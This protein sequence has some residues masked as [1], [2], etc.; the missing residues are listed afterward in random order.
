M[1]ESPPCHHARDRDLEPATHHTP[2]NGDTGQRCFTLLLS[3]CVPSSGCSQEGI[4][5]ASLVPEDHACSPSCHSCVVPSAP[6][7]ATGALLFLF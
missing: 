5:Q 4:P 3:N 1:E 6:A 2:Q 7:A